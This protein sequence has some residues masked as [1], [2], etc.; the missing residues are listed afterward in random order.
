MSNLQC[1]FLQSP[2]NVWRL[3]SLTVTVMLPNVFRFPRSVTDIMIASIVKMKKLQCVSVSVSEFLP[4]HYAALCIHI[5][6]NK[7]ALCKLEY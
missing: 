5:I 4:I 6:T 2:R 3:K 1:P 7:F